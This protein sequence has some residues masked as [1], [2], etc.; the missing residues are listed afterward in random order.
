MTNETE[1][2]DAM[3]RV[4]I[5]PLRFHSGLWKFYLRLVFSFT[6]LGAPI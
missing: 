2:Y 4:L 1:L 6:A 3:A 5:S